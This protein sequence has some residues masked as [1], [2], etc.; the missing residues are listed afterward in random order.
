MPDDKTP[1]KGSAR[2]RSIED[3]LRILVPEEDVVLT[4]LAG[5]RYTTTR[6]LTARQQIHLIRNLNALVRIAVAQGLGSPDDLSFRGLVEALIVVASDERAFDAIEAIFLSAHAGVV[7][8]ARENAKDPKASPMDLFDLREVAVA[9]VPT[10]GLLAKQAA[11]T[12]E[13][14]L[15]KVAALTDQDPEEPTPTA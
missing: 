6:V 9:I 13:A 8:K 2:T 7:Q 1:T 14:L 3:I 11:D 12:M 10:F 4:D 5:N 15:P